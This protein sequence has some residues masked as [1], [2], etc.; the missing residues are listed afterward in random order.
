MFRLLVKHLFDYDEDLLSS[1]LHY[2]RFESLLYVNIFLLY[3]NLCEVVTS[4]FPLH[5]SRDNMSRLRVLDMTT[6][7]TNLIATLAVW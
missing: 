7:K 4:T 2:L 6:E 1:T 3:K 5:N